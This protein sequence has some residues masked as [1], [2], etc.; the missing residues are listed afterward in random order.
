VRGAAEVRDE[1]VRGRRV[2]G[3]EMRIAGDV[4]CL[5]VEEDIAKEVVD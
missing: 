4:I 2:R 5:L 3:E 1:S